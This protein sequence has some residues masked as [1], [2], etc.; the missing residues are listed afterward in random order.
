MC[1]GLQDNNTLYSVTVLENFIYGMVES[2]MIH[3]IDNLN[4]SLDQHGVEWIQIHS[5]N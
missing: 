3:P 1:L 4:T 2:F 5:F